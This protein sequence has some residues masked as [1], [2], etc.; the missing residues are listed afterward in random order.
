MGKYDAQAA[1]A[2]TVGGEVPASNVKEIGVYLNEYMM[3]RNALSI[4]L[5][6][7]KTHTAE[8][9]LAGEVEVNGVSLFEAL[10]EG[11]LMKSRPKQAGILVTTKTNPK[12]MS[13]KERHDK[14]ENALAF[15]VCQVNSTVSTTDDSEEDDNAV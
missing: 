12:F 15:I 11:G 1:A 4:L 13:V 9:I 6:V 7:G 10:K 5:E 8:Q 2:A 3:K 14:N